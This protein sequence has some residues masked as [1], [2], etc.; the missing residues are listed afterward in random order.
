MHTFEKRIHAFGP[1]SILLRLLNPPLLTI[2][3]A[4]F[5]LFIFRNFTVDD[6]FIAWSHGKNLVEHGVY[7]FNTTGRRVQQAH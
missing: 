7:A 2:F 1:S 3:A 4:V 6:A 5:W